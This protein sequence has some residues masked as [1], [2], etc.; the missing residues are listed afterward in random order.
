MQLFVYNKA[1]TV[2]LYIYY[3]IFFATAAAAVAAFTFYKGLA[4]VY[5][6]PSLYYYTK[7]I[8]I[9]INITYI[10]SG[11]QV[12]SQLFVYYIVFYKII[13]RQ[14]NNLNF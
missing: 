14:F 5:Y 6:I 2:F 1:G 13:C 9:I 3:Y 8:I 4:K 7:R 12:Y 11:F 10:F